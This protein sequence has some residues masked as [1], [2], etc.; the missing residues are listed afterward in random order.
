[1]KIDEAYNLWADTYDT[2]DNVTRDLELAISK[3]ILAGKSF[4]KIIELGCGTGKNTEWL[5][6]KCDSLLGVDFSSE[7]LR[8]AKRKIKSDKVKFLQADLT[9][10]WTFNN[11]SADLVTS[12]LILEHINNLDFIFAEAHKS[13]SVN[14]QF[15]ICELHPFKQYAGS[16]ARFELNN[17][18][19]KLETFVHHISDYLQ[20][21]AKNNFKLLEL[22]EWFDE[23]NRAEI[24]RLVSF[25]FQKK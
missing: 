2:N 18:I 3:S 4:S 14:G 16:K 10:E 12:S 9:K 17:E 19:V 7:M 20:S 22:N 11:T 6:D 23:K 21:A 5:I 13:L 8:K 24:P 25:L 15:Y 1:M